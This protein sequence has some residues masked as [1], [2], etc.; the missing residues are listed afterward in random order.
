M[1]LK[2]IFHTFLA[3]SIAGFLKLSYHCEK[4]FALLESFSV[5]FTQNSP[6]L[7]VDGYYL[8]H[9]RCKH[10]NLFTVK[11]LSVFTVQ[12]QLQISLDFSLFVRSCIFLVEALFPFA[13]AAV[14]NR[15]LCC[16]QKLRFG[17]AVAYFEL[18]HS[19]GRK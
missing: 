17:K 8:R 15:R 12:A 9:I 13:F 18:F 3:A 11:N 19:L 5:G 6:F 2:L 1:R 16:A 14:F 10:R 4:S 7:F